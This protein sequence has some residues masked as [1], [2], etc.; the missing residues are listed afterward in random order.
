M[1]LSHRFKPR[2]TCNK[3]MPTGNPHDLCLKCLGE[4]HQIERFRICKVFCPRMKKE[5]DFHLKQL[6]RQ[7]FVLIWPR[8]NRMRKD[9]DQRDPLHQCSPA[10]QTVET[11]WHHSHTPVPYKWHRKTDGLFPC[12][13]ESGASQH[14]R[15]QCIPHRCT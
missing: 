1:S 9:S 10:W 4:A 6:L 15:Q 3:P 2:G 14:A 12:A 5:W 8:A 7:F 13:E 11:S